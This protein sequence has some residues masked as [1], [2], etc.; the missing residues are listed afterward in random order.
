MGDRGGKWEKEGEKEGGQW[1]RER[2]CVGERVRW[3][4][5]ERVS[6]RKGG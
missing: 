4:D 1:K 2:G 5:T 6:R 3:R